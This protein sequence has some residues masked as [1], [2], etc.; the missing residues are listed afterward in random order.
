LAVDTASTGTPFDRRLLGTNVPA[1]LS[2]W[3]L[4]DPTFQQ[5]VKESGT[6]LIRMPGGSWSTVYDWRAC[7]VAPDTECEWHWAVSPSEYLSFLRAVELPG[8]WTVRF[9][10]TAQEAAALV[11]FFNGA[12][13]DDRVIGVDRNGYDWKTVGHWAELRAAGGNPEP[14]PLRYWEVGNEIWGAKQSAGPECAPWGWEE[15]WTCE[16]D[17][18]VNGDAEHDGYRDFV[19]A[20][21]AVDPTISIGAVGV[22]RQ[23]DWGNWGN[24]VIDAAGESIGFY[25]VHEYGFNEQ[26]NVDEVLGRADDLWPVIG[27]DTAAAFAAAGIDPLVAVTE[28][29]L[30]TGID[31]DQQSLMAR[32]VNMLYL[33]DTI[34]QMAVSGIDIATQWN[35]ANGAVGTGADYGLVRVETFEPYPS[36]YGLAAW[37]NAG[38]TL[39]PVGSQFDFAQLSAYAT[40]STEGMVQMLVINKTDAPIGTTVR[41]EGAADADVAL[42]T[43]RT[44]LLADDVQFDESTATL[45]AQGRA[46]VTLAPFSL[47][48]LTVEM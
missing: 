14:Y 8:M 42:S 17:E 34:G 40:A 7:E 36:F 48:T 28:Y 5:R 9:D 37:K 16:G 12:V 19:E 44:E 10:G 2:G 43:V 4:A 11:A 24:E 23:D 33:A 46:A 35:L 26:P 32:G 3:Q 30:V 29:G 25:V 18:Y 22:G 20:M 13:G 39:L 41:F 45:D 31:L 6:T 15:T 1:W 21:T 47:T 27:A 38:D